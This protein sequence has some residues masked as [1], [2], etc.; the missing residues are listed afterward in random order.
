MTARRCKSHDIG[1]RIV[2]DT[3]DR[4]DRLSRS[5]SAAAS[6]ARPWSAR[7]L[8]EFLPREDLLAYLEAV[9]RVYNLDG[10]RDNKY[11]ARIKILVHE[12]GHRGHPR[13]RSRRNSP[14][15]DQAHGRRSTA[16]EV[17]AHRRLFR[18]AAYES[19][20]DVSRKLEAGAVQG[21]RTSRVSSSTTSSATSAP[22]YAA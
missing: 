21:R 8:R 19:L 4:R 20:P 22:G 11:K 6:A 12:I 5:W 3:H 7:C 10:R 17:G 16:E 2:R 15:I 9:L 18:A 1:V 14:Q 13:R